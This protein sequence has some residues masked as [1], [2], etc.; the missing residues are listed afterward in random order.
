MAVTIPLGKMKI[1]DKLRALE[2]IWDDLQRTP[3]AVASPSWHADVLRA[4]MSRV[5]AGKS[6]F[7]DWPDAKRSIRERAR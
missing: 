5:R 7:C 4:R 6:A 2:E 1:S 3:G